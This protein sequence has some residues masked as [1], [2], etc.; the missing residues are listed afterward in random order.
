MGNLSVLLTINLTNDLQWYN[1]LH[2]G[3]NHLTFSVCTNT[4]IASTLYTYAWCLTCPYLPLFTFLS[5]L[6]LETRNELL[7]CTSKYLA[8]LFYS[9]FQILQVSCQQFTLLNS[10]NTQTHKYIYIYIYI[11][12]SLNYQVFVCA[13]ESVCLYVCVC[14]THATLSLNQITT[15]THTTKL[16]QKQFL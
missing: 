1:P 7:A 10:E 3:M 5:W 4:I 6:G 2:P 14:H 13:C 11:L 16:F 9:L 15:N 12:M 8:I